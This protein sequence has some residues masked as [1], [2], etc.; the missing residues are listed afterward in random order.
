MIILVLW[1]EGERGGGEKG[2]GRE[3]REGE[4]GEGEKGR[5]GEGERGRGGREGEKGR[6]GE[7]RVTFILPDNG[8]PQTT[9]TDLVSCTIPIAD[10]L[11]EAFMHTII[12]TSNSAICMPSKIPKMTAKAV[13]IAYDFAGA[14]SSIDMPTIHMVAWYKYIVLAFLMTER[15]A[16]VLRRP[17]AMNAPRNRKSAAALSAGNPTSRP[18]FT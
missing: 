1:V 17:T 13:N 12:W 18:Y 11:C 14:T 15:S 9:K 16:A 5:G 2:R 7:E 10:A 3:G 8:G 6:G 4:R